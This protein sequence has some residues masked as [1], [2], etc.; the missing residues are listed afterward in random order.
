MVVLFI[1][2]LICLYINDY[3]IPPHIPFSKPQLIYHF[4]NSHEQWSYLRADNKVA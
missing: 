1:P 4:I 2:N 3:S